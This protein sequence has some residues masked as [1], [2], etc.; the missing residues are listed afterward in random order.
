MSMTASRA[1]KVL[2]ERRNILASLTAK[3]GGT[4]APGTPRGGF[5]I[6][7]LAPFTLGVGRHHEVRDLH[8]TRDGE[9][10]S[11]VVDQDGRYLAAIIGIDGPGRVQHRHAMTKRKA[12]SGAQLGFETCGE[13]QR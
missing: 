11:A 7:G 2:R 10:F 13:R 4:E 3:S 8:A 12:R 1:S 9:G 5:Q 6:G